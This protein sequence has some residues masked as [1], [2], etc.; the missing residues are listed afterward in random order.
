MSPV[1]PA[2]RFKPLRGVF[3]GVR[4]HPPVLTPVT[5]ALTDSDQHP[6]AFA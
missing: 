4:R 2:T 6:E 1:K 5:P 3:R